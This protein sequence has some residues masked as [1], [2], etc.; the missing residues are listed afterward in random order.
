MPQHI[1]RELSPPT[2]SSVTPPP[3][4]PPLTPQPKTQAAAAPVAAAT[5]HA[6]PFLF[7]TSRRSL[8]A[9]SLSCLRKRMEERMKE[10]RD[11][12]KK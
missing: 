10:R 3:F 5:D 8:T 1:L 2:S 6:G 11:E 12:M 7:P 4:I 9:L